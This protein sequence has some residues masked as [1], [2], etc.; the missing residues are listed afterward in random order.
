MA[1]EAKLLQ[2]MSQT[3]AMTP[4]LQQA[5][6]L[7]QLG[8]LEYKEAIE[9]EL[10]ENPILEEQSDEPYGEERQSG[11]ETII[12]E[13]GSLDGP[14]D[15][16]S[17]SSG[18]SN[19]GNSDG[20]PD[21][22]DYMDRF[23]DYQGASSPKGLI[24]FENRP[25]L[26]N[27]IFKTETLAE[28]LQNQ[29]R[30][31]D[32]SEEEMHVAL[33]ISGNLDR[34]GYLCVTD[35]EILEE[36]NTDIVV[37]EKVLNELRQLEPIGLTARNL[38]ECLIIQLDH[39]GLSETVA[40]KIV[41][42]HLD[43]VEK[44]KYD[45]ITKDLKISLNQVKDA[46]SII[47]TLEPRPGRQFADEDTRYVTPDVY[48][49][50]MNGEWVI[51]LNEDGLPKLRVSPYYMQVLQEQGKESGA[52]KSYLNE[53]LKAASW[54]IKSIHQRQQTIFKV[55]ESI[56][57]FQTEFLD[58]GVDKLKPLVLREVASDIGMHESTVSRVTNNKFVHTPQGVFELKYFF[59]TGIK[60]ADG[61]VSS[62]SVKEK[63]R[64]LIASENPK[65]PLSDQDIV[66]FMQKENIDIARRTV[67][68]YRESM[69][70]PSSSQRKNLF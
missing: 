46:I 6:K 69:S 12:I 59:T 2:K 64:L 27:T 45:C 20:T 11:S 21:W 57:K 66:E 30:F 5:I 26:E 63:I 3:L 60:G 13:A 58:H 38:Q 52:A 17:G 47:Q 9:K 10:L 62:N 18:E 44:R 39:Q 28:Y 42:E 19:S 61:D 65:K 49:Q 68:K 29:F 48:V 35:E 67:A 56:I 51:T 54:L 15:D 31:L 25:Q 34:D 43:K 33:Y 8:R 14:N 7:L 24:D 37:V 22:D 41:A 70:I 4:Q 40:A 32:L 36:C 53:R 16:S 50:K 1:L 23:S 55:T